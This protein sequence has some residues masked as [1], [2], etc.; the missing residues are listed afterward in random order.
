[1]SYYQKVNA[2]LKTELY[3]DLIIKT[4]PSFKKGSSLAKS[5]TDHQNFFNIEALVEDMMAI[6]SNGK[7]EF[8]DGIHEDFSDGSECKTGTLHVNGTT[9]VAEITSVKSKFGKLKT[10]AVRCVILNPHFKKLHFVFVPKAAVQKIMST[11]DGSIK[12]NTSMWLRYNKKDA[13]F[14]KCFVKYGIIE[15]NTFEELSQEVNH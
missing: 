5:L 2:E 12:K 3:T 14:N 10:G 9:S 4:H 15:Y 11:K 7:Y 1:M 8:I 6:C 13:S